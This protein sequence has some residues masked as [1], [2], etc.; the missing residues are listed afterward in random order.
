MV[1]ACTINGIR[2]Y[3]RWYTPIQPVESGE[4]A[5]CVGLHDRK[6]AKKRLDV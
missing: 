4:A 1:F 3:H 6:Y 2:V 5:G